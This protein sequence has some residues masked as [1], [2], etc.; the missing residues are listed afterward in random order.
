MAKGVDKKII[1]KKKKK[2]CQKVLKLRNIFLK[3]TI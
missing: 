1:M 3:I 2:T